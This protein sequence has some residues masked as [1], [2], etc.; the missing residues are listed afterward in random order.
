MLSWD[1][2]PFTQNEKY[3]VTTL[4]LG[5]CKL[6]EGTKHPSGDVDRWEDFLYKVLNTFYTFLYRVK[7]VSFRIKTSLEFS[8]E[9]ISVELAFLASISHL[10]KKN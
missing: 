10:R 2:A 1:G 3:R 9:L 7:I 8:S 6:S 5:R 4:P